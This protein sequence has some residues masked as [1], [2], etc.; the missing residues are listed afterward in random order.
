M[1]DHLWAIESFAGRSFFEQYN[2]LRKNAPKDIARRSESAAGDY[3]TERGVAV[4]PITGPLASSWPDWLEAIEQVGS[5]QRIGAAF[6]R[7]VADPRAESILLAIDSP[8]GSVVG[9]SELGDMIY[10]ARGKKPIVA[11]SAGMVASAAYYL[12][13]QADK[14]YASRMDMIGSIGTIMVVN[15]Y[16]EAFAKAGIR[17]VVLSSAPKD[18]PFKSTGVP[19]TAIT[20]A[21][22]ADLQR[23]VDGYFADFKAAV[24]RGR[25][26]PDAQFTKAADGRVWLGSEALTMGLVD[27]VQSAGVTLAKLHKGAA[28]Q[29]APMRNGHA[30]RAELALEARRI[31]A[32]KR[33]R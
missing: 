33:R 23:I 8:G 26:M 21:Q 11:Q 12:A 17:P 27:G 3:T 9:L 32:L 16:S 29:P 6:A 30:Q 14:F 4:I 20:P 25:R 19:G 10:A 24:Q 28:G 13:A 1:K 18:R 2:A 31:A 7:A 15:D 22:E 5:Y